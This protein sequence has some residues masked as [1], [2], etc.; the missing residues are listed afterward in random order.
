[1]KEI[2]LTVYGAE[3]KC[4]SCINLPSAKETKE[5][6]EAA[7]TRKFPDVMIHFVYCDIN[8]PKTTEEKTF[9][10]KIQNDDYFYPLVVINS[11][12]VAEGNLKIRTIFEKIADELNDSNNSKKSEQL[13]SESP[14]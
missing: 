12:V 10:E 13:I 8:E 7:V 2:R 6:L 4:A 14:D 3:V 11:E 1:M 5:W 9:S